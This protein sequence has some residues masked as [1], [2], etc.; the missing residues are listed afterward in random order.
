MTNQVFFKSFIWKNKR[1]NI[2]KHLHSIPVLYN[3]YTKNMQKERPK[4]P[5]MILTPDQTRKKTS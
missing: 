1:I 4:N 5:F 3:I 2:Q